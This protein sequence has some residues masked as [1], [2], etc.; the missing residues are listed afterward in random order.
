MFQVTVNPKVNSNIENFKDMLD[1]IPDVHIPMLKDGD[2]FDLYGTIKKKGAIYYGT[3]CLVQTGGLPPKAKRG[4]VPV[5]LVLDPDEGLGHYTSFFFDPTNNIVMV[6]AN[7]NGITANGVAAF[8]KRNF[9]EHI[10]K[11]EFKVVINPADLTRLRRMSEIKS[12]T[13]SIAGLQGGGILA[14]DRVR[15][16]IGELNGIADKTGTSSINLTLSMGKAGGSL[17]KAAIFSIF[18]SIN[19][20]DQEGSVLKME[21]TGSEEGDDTMRVIDFITN[22]VMID[23]TYIRPRHFNDS[24]ITA[25]ILDAIDQYDQ[26][27][28]EISTAYRVRD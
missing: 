5:P 10:R 26:I 1:N 27:R 13:L 6:Q 8:F 16:S 3:F 24:T 23:A 9:T 20:A 28:D 7:R 21:V 4:A 18:R 11:I 22:K 15:R 19:A 17:K 12:V 25:I 14:N 2:E